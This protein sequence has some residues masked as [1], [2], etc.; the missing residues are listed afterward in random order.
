MIRIR[1]SNDTHEVQIVRFD[2]MG[3]AR[4]VTTASAENEYAWAMGK[5]Y[6]GPDK[7]TNGVLW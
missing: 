7:M 3:H 4:S 1:V 5:D 2:V 6:H